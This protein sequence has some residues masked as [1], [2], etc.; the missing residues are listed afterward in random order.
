MIA[1]TTACPEQI[2]AM[3]E[4]LPEFQFKNSAEDIASRITGKAH[5]A[6]I[7]RLDEADAG[8]MVCYEEDDGVYYNWIMGVLPPFRR[9]GIGKALI[10]HFAESALLLNRPRLRVK[11][12]NKYRSML[13]L[14]IDTNFHIIAVQDDKITFESDAERRAAGAC[15]KR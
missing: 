5:T 1:I 13:R 8:F 3:V 11:T 10:T 12:M 4:M 2:A 6:V 9:A 7:A 15:C 14:L